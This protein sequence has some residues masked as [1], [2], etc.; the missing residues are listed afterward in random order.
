MIE[1]IQ[2]HIIFI[3]I[4]IIAA[5]II[6]LMIYDFRKMKKRQEKQFEE[7]KSRNRSCDDM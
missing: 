4:P 5:F 1:I 2:I 7:E 3:G 6:A